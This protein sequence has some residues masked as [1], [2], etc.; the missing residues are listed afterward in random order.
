MRRMS[1]SN[2]YDYDSQNDT[3]LFYGGDGNYKSS[4]DLD[5]IIIDFNDENYLM[6]VEILDASNRLNISKYDLRNTKYFDMNL[7][8]TE[9][10]IH[11]TM[12]IKISKRNK[13]VA[14]TLDA[15][16]TNST[17]IP[18]STQGIEVSC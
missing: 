18:P 16:A 8:V 17:N 15:V 10:S 1:K 7:E 5:G 4:I 9:E 13:S 6:G 14:H 11:V 3:I 2:K 12:E